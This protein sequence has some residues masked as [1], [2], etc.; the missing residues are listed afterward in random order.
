[1][2]VAAS[3]RGK[4]ECAL[5]DQHRCKSVLGADVSRCERN[6]SVRGDGGTVNLSTPGLWCNCL[7]FGLTEQLG[8]VETVDG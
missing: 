2:D 8:W 1:M 3:A 6:S 7:D 4:R 5:V